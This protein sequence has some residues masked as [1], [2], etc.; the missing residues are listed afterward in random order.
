MYSTDTVQLMLNT[1]NKITELDFQ[2]INYLLAIFVECNL[3]KTRKLR[4]YHSSDTYLY[5]SR[6]LKSFKKHR[7]NHALERIHGKNERRGAS[8]SSE[9]VSSTNEAVEDVDLKGIIKEEDEE[10]EQ[11][12]TIDSALCKDEQPETRISS[13]EMERGEGVLVK[14]ISLL[15]KP[16][17]ETSSALSI[18]T[19][20]INSLISPERMLA[21]ATLGLNPQEASLLN[22]LRAD[23]AEKQRERRLVFFYKTI[24]VDG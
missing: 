5:F 24:I 12:A 6:Y 13:S 17:A 20:S 3:G 1:E 8:E 18:A 21:E 11:D 15:Q 4:N 19:T 22:F 16:E 9:M 7:L 10:E 2:L 14:H 23:A